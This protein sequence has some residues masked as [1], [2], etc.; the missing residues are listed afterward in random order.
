MKRARELFNSLLFDLYP[1]EEIDAL[2]SITMKSVFQFSTTE[3]LLKS[4]E[5]LA[6]G[7][8]QQIEE[9]ANQL[10]K[11]VPLQYI[12]GETAFYDL[13]FF[14][15]PNVLIPRNETEELVDLIVKNYRFRSPKILDIGTGSGC[16]PIALKKNIPNALV[17]SCDISES[18]L[19][20]ARKNASFHQADVHF[21]QFDILSG[22]VFPENDFDILVSNP[23]YI[24]MKEKALMQQNVLQNEPH[25]ALFVPNED[26]LLFYRAIVEKYAY[27]LNPLGEIYF[28]I[29]EAFGPDIQ[30]L[31]GLNGFNSK[32][33]NDINGKNRIVSAQRGTNKC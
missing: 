29:N 1:K 26:P 9:I 25:L 20:V 4:A 28:E 27:L 14:V 17:F 31:L 15:N 6:E 18:A 7:D 21:L 10:Q 5:K 33:I 23:P 24:T 2:F 13:K 19:E 3:L 30:H 11:N 32:I 22:A 16:I 8:F 12:L